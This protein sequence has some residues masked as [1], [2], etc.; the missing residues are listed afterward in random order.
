MVD[1]RNVGTIGILR[2]CKNWTRTCIPFA[3]SC[4]T[5]QEESEHQRYVSEHLRSHLHSIIQFYTDDEL[6]IAEAIIQENLNEASVILGVKGA[7]IANL[8][9]DKT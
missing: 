8:L 6:F 9:A 7:P 1:V 2:E 5:S 4:V 3:T